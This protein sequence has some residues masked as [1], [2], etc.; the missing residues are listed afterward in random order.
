MPP[1]QDGF[2]SAPT[3][4][5]MSSLIIFLLDVLPLVISTFLDISSLFEVNTAAVL[6]C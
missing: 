4:S 2:L 5:E 3:V 1:E 6:Y